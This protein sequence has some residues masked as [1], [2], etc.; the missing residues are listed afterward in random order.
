M[1][2]YGMALDY[3]NCINCKACEVEVSVNIVKMRLVNPFV[4]PMRHIMMIMVLFG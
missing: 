2:R 1:A 4:L 3:K